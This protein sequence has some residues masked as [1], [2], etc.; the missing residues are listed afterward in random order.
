MGMGGSF[1]CARHSKWKFFALIHLLAMC[2]H[3]DS[4]NPAGFGS[5][6]KLCGVES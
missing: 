3:A 2:G 5:C 4:I 6:R 1:E